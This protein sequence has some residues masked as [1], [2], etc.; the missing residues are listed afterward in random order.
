M[1][2]PVNRFL[3]QVNFDAETKEL[4]LIKDGIV[5]NGGE[6]E[7]PQGIAMINFNLVATLNAPEGLQA[8]FPAN[9]IG[10]FTS[11]ADT[12]SPVQDPL[13]FQVNWFTPSHF[14]LIDFNSSLVRNSHAFN[15]IVAYDGNTFGADPTI[16][17]MPPDG[18]T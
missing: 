17:N 16:V 14:T 1:E 15:V 18:T 8:E 3:I 6:I 13:N 12:Q 9:P 4:I 7:I 10:W 2:L 11:T 5:I